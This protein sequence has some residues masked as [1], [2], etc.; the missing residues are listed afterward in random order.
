MQRRLGGF[1]R[2]NPL[3]GGAVAAVVAVT[4][5]CLSP[6]WG[7]GAAIALAAVAWWLTS[8]RGAL[9]A[10]ICAGASGGLLWKHEHDRAA[11]T[12]ALVAVPRPAVSGTLLA[13]ARATTSGWSAPV[14]L[15]GGN[16]LPIAIAWW[17]GEGEPPVAGAKVSA[18]GKFADAE[19]PRNPGEFDQ[20][21]WFRQ[22]G[23]A[24]MF[25]ADRGSGEVATGKIAAFGAW[26]RKGF[27]EAVTI[28]LP[29]DSQEADVIRAVVIGEYPRGE[30]AL[31]AAYRDSGTLHAFSVSGMHVALAGIICWFVLGRFG[32]SRQVAVPLLIALMF[33]YSWIS[34]NSPPAL[35]SAWMGA[36][37]LAAFALRRRPSLLNGLGA[38][39]LCTAL[40]E[41]RL[42]LL[43]GVQLSYGVV[44]VIGFL[45]EPCRHWM[46]RFVAHD[47]YLPRVLLTKW[48][49][50]WHWLARKGSD[51]VAVAAVAWLGSTPL[52]LWHFRMTTPV[53]ILAAIPMSLGIF[54]LMVLAAFSTFLFPFS[55]GAASQVNR[56]NGWVARGCTATAESLAS[57]PF[58]NTH[59]GRIQ[60]PFLL[61]Y[62]LEY[63]GGAACFASGD[64][65][66]LL[67]C[68]DRRTFHRTVLPS[69]RNL[70]VAP[71]AVVLSHADGGHVGG[72][73]ELLQ[74]YRIRQVVMPV[75]KARSTLYKAWQTEA[76]AAGAKL[77]TAAEGM[78]LPLADGAWLEVVAVPD[79]A[80]KGGVADDQVAI[81]R[82]HWQ[83]WKILFVNDAGQKTERRLLE[84]D[85]DLRADVLIAGH[86][87]SDLSLGDGFVQAV[88]P[89][90]IIVSNA[91]FPV[92][93]HLDPAKTAWWRGQ[94]IEVFDQRESGGV[95]VRP[96][97]QGLRLEGFVSGRASVLTR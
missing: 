6:E 72:G 65:A 40:W 59:F 9:F 34:G 15:S 76:P 42:L 73:S 85:V 41:G 46:G 82:L 75:E 52:T 77:L 71:D 30:D 17:L 28:G 36:V 94:G 96:V 58:G 79:S 37:F 24:A 51:D 92:T 26:I 44:A 91:A 1:F 69:L 39:L 88:A 33:G 22:Q 29:P 50:R 80:A 3:F 57:L 81:Y 70:E 4:F 66:V 56:L 27:R 53:A 47:D 55:P 86:H 74:T 25:L 12:A 7:T 93:E 95:T 19:P 89:K 84:A 90:A 38:V 23:L 68:G 43:P 32:V 49:E 35:R 63:G 18:R 64:S 48:Q 60:K 20:V 87:R 83:R 5:W 61:V 67:D 78:R 97:E 16:G 10:L 45:G 13:D 62:D 31:I 8:W 2:L 21:A 14:R 11:A 54:G